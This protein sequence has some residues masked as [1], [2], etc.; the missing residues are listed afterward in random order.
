MYILGSAFAALALAS[1]AA[2]TPPRA[3]DASNLNTRQTPTTPSTNDVIIQMFGWNWDSIATECATIGQ[4]GYSYIQVSPP[5]EHIIG[6]AWWTDYQAVSY[7]LTSK[8]G[9]RNQFA[10]MLR[11]CHQAGVK[12]II[13]AIINHMTA[14]TW[15]DGIGGTPFTKFNYQGSWTEENFHNCN[16]HGDNRIRKYGERFE[17]QNCE[18]HGLA[19]LKTETEPV[20]ARLAAF[21]EDLISLGVDGFR[22]DAAK[23]M[24]AGDIRNIL[25]RL[26]KSVYITQEAT[27]SPGEQVLPSEYLIN[28]YLQEFAYN[29]ELRSAFLGGNVAAL[30]TIEDRGWLSRK[31]VNVFVANHDSERST[32]SVVMRY[33]STNNAYILAHVFSLAHPY[34]QP[35]VLSGYGFEQ[36]DDGAPDNGAGRCS[37]NGGSGG[38]LC[39]HRW[40][41][42]AG[43]VG[44]RKNAGDTDATNWQGST[45]S[46]GKVAFGRGSNGFVVI[47]HAADAWSTTF[48]TSL[49]DGTY[50]DV[51]NG[52][53]NAEGRC[54]GTS[55]TVSGRSFTASVSPRDALA[56]HIGARLAVTM[57]PPTSQTRPGWTST[58]SQTGTSQAPS[59]TVISPPSSTE[60]SQCR[61]KGNQVSVTFRS[62]VPTALGEN[63]YLIGS[64]PQ[65]GA[66][67]PRRGIRMSADTHPVWTTTVEVPASR[68]FEYKYYKTNNHG[69]RRGKR[70]LI[71]W[72]SGDN[73]KVATVSNGTQ[74][75]DDDWR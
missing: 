7:K 41:A 47:N 72:L 22:I 43:M 42:I 40:T 57:P 34:G 14:Q 64:L 52:S 65:L 3:H 17:T 33:N 31:Q 36:R 51:I 71:T 39:Q 75:L 69:G 73:L 46:T 26:S 44:F 74:T 45:T 30:R 29:R 10:N 16:R 53:L 32:N 49:T 4:L 13:D 2:S 48:T 12:V 28:G 38:W 67:N 58:V 20:R 25:D 27:Y 9:N 1:V 56:I 66:W 54:T 8:R 24:P 70:Q 68:E 61:R 15:G 11:R 5:Q 59:G 62:N 6:G 50:C 18:L 55:V 35:T 21:L 23:H 19:D 63:V 60:T 37:A